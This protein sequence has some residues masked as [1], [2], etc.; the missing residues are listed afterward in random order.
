[1]ASRRAWARTSR[2]RSVG[3]PPRSTSVRANSRRWSNSSGLASWMG[4]SSRSMNAS[5][6]SSSSVT[7]AGMD[8][9]KGRHSLVRG[10]GGR[11][12]RL[13]CAD[14]RP[15]DRDQPR[16]VRGAR[17]R[18][19]AGVVG[20]VVCL[21]AAR[22]AE[23]HGVH[24]PRRSVRRTQPRSGPGVRVSP[25]P[26]AMSA[27]WSTTRRRCGP[28]CATRARTSGARARCAIRDPS[29][30]LIEIVD[31]RDVQFSKA[32]AVL[33]GHGFGRPGEVAV[34]DR[35]TAGQGAHRRLKC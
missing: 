16:G 22:P 4:T 2:Q 23:D 25:T 5:I 26:D 3:M 6:D 12:R 20:A 7:S 28:R 1:M 10:R 24:R 30:N 9:S 18:R 11:D 13:S 32:D 35:R 15:G 33:R 14:G 21:R 8:R 19:G 29:G 17:P 34:G 31:Y 27:W